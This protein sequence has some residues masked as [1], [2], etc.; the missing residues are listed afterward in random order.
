[1]FKA[2]IK[3]KKYTQERRKENGRRW[4]AWVADWLKD[5]LLGN[6]KRNRKMQDYQTVSKCAVL[7]VWWGE[8]VFSKT[9]RVLKEIVILD[10][11]LLS[12]RTLISLFGNDMLGSFT[13][14]LQE[15]L[16]EGRIDVEGTEVS[17]TF[18]GSGYVLGGFVSS[19][20]HYGK[21]VCFTW[22]PK[23]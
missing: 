6:K 20:D 2:D 17:L 4:S 19:S 12:M 13:R 14:L 15:T 5:S 8:N 23:L 11:A 21:E 22:E 10:K 9:S 16:A 3:K 7:G 18:V 1:M